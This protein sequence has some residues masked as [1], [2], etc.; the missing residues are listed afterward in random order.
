MGDA[1]PLMLSDGRVVTI[2]SIRPDDADRLNAFFAALSAEARRFRFFSQWR[3]GPDDATRMAD[4]SDAGRGSVAVV[5]TV[6]TAAGDDG[7]D[8]DEVIVGDARSCGPHD[9][10]AEMAIAVADAYHGC[11]LGRVLLDELARRAS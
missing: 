4:L 6:T 2:R 10:V 9:S 5:A 11:G 8:G 7:R 1:R 3:M